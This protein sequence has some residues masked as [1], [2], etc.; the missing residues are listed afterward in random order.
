[1]DHKKIFASA[2]G[3]SIVLALVILGTGNAAALGSPASRWGS[4][5]ASAVGSGDGSNGWSEQTAKPPTQPS[6]SISAKPNVT[7]TLGLWRNMRPTESYLNGV[8]LLPPGYSIDCQSADQKAEGWAVGSGGVV[9]RYCNGVWDHDIVPT[10]GFEDLYSVQGISPTLAVAVGDQGAIQMYEFNDT[11]GAWV[12]VKHPIPGISKRLNSVSLVKS[13][14]SYSGWSVGSADSTLGNRGTLV[15]VTINPPSGSPN[16]ISYWSNV[17]GNYSLPAVTAYQAVHTLST[18]DSWAVGATSTGGIIIHWNGS[19]WSLV[20]SVA[21]A[22]YGIRMKSAIEGWAVGNGGAIYR[23]NG[24]TWSKVTSPTT[25]VLTDID[26]APGGEQWIVGY[27]NALLKYVSGSWQQVPP[28]DLRTDAFDFRAVDFTSGHGWLVG[29]NDAKTIGGQILE[30]D[31]GLWFAVT[32]PTDNRLNA[33]AAVS[34][35]DAW[36]VGDSDTNGGTIIHWDGK[37]WQRWYQPDLPIPS[38]DLYAISMVS[39]TDGWAAGDSLGGLGLLLHWDGK[40]WAPIR[41]GSPVSVRINGLDTFK[42]SDPNHPVVAWAVADTGNGFAEYV[43][44]DPDVWTALASCGGAWYQMFGVSM[45]SGSSPPGNW[46]AWAVGRRRGNAYP[47]T[48]GKG[49]FTRF[50]GGCGTDYAWDWYQD[51]PGDPNATKLY[52][53]KMIEG[54]D[55]YAVGNQSDMATVYTYLITG[56]WGLRYM[57]PAGGTNPSNFYSVDLLSS[58]GIGWF[59]GYYTNVGQGS[60]KWAYISYDDGAHGWVNEEHIVPVNGVN[61]YHRPIASIDMLSDDMGWAV[62][63]DPLDTSAAAKKSVIYQYPFPNFTLDTH[64]ASRAARPTSSTTFTVTVNSIGGLGTDVS[65]SF[66]YGL[67]AWATG[68]TISP[69]TIHAGQVATINVSLNSAPIGYQ[70]LTLRGSSIFKSGDVDFPVARDVCLDLYVTEHPIDSVSPD[71]G[72]Y[73]TVVTITGSNFGNIPA[74]SRNTA[75]NH[76]SWTPTSYS[77]S[78]EVQLADA[79]VLTWT[80][81]QITFR[82]PDSP[83]LFTTKFPITG[84]VKV[85]ASGSNSNDNNTFK[86]DPWITS[87]ST[88]AGAGGITVS[89]TGTS[90]GNDPGST[91]RQTEFEHVS[92]DA[93]TVNLADFVSWS[94]TSIVFTVPLSSPGGMVKVTTNGFESNSVGFGSAANKS[95]LPL[96]KR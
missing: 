17:T 73:G 58:S 70:C 14:N 20:Q 83:G 92:L 82:P 40:R 55:G 71:H 86:M 33:V 68:T 26:Y 22:L 3:L 87:I 19:Q 94:N 53:I 77:S 56:T 12:W 79:D 74:G 27:N 48:P 50:Q 45:I 95:Y 85:T 41:T 9:L 81:T 47:Y 29:Q 65:L 52:G 64:P 62:G 25:Q 89:L 30:Y 15:Q 32:P 93:A 38:A 24:S 78:Q 72:R 8:S 80:D 66:P 60:K 42:T 1:M 75:T 6:G 49:V 44:F 18:T 31:N 90:F 67:P 46:D 51:A 57:Q 13:G 59:A 76:V 69:A 54:P 4:T 39:A 21:D 23:Y 63:G 88:T 84:R 16:P 61:I 7:V 10:Y 28:Q 11:R 34:V 36:A 5:L 96:I 43:T 37:H 91:L 2:L 35:N